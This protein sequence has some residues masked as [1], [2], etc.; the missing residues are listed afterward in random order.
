M[1]RTQGPTGEAPVAP[2]LTLTDLGGQKLSL[3]DYRGKVVLLDFWATWCG[4]CR[5]EIPGLVELQRRY[6]DQGLQIL[7]IAMDEDPHAVR[8]FYRDYKMNYP[9]AIGDESVAELF[10]GI[11]GLPTSF[12]IGRDGRIRGKHVG[13][14]SISTFE[15]QIRELLA[16]T[17]SEQAAEVQ[18][19][20]G[21][22]EADSVARD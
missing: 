6:R 1:T 18:V 10:G 17:V 22:E 11:L 20:S 19:G 3:S 16:G 4:P 7:G 12:V 13:L 2:E 8:Q 15:M 5:I 9:V 21:S 14:T